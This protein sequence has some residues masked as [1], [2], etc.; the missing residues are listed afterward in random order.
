MTD[1]IQTMSIP[2]PTKK[3][4]LIAALVAV[5]AVVLLGCGAGSGEELG[6][7]RIEAT[8]QQQC[9]ES[10]ML[11]IDQHTTRF[12]QLRNLGAVMHWHEGGGLFVGSY[13]SGQGS[14][15][16]DEHKLVDMRVG[17]SQDKPS[18]VIERRLHIAAQ[19]EG[20]PLAGYLGFVGTLR[21]DYAVAYQSQCDD[22]LAGPEA[23]AETMPCAID[24]A[25]DAERQD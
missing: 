16:V 22:L 6:R 13:N 25:L 23:I 8:R 17:D 2:N 4:A 10:G 1:P 19:F 14:F 24:L 18:C 20:D 15:E 11:A 3:S 21:Y 5:P 12:A 9:A 7:Y